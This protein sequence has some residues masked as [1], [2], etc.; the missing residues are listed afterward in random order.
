MKRLQS[1]F[2]SQPWLALLLVTLM[3]LGVISI[4]N[5][6]GVNAGIGGGFFA[7]RPQNGTTVASSALNATPGV[8]TILSV[9]EGGILTS[10]L[11]E[12]DSADVTGVPD[13]DLIVTVDGTP[14]TIAVYNGATTWPEWVQQIARTIATSVVSSV[15]ATYLPAP[16]DTTLFQMDDAGQNLFRSALNVNG[17]G[18]LNS[19]SIEVTEAIVANAGVGA[20]SE[21]YLRII[22]DGV[23][24]DILL[25]SSASN[26]WEADN[27]T[28]VNAPGNGANVGD[29]IGLDLTSPFTFTTN[30]QVGLFQVNPMT[31]GGVDMFIRYSTL[32]GSGGGGGSSTITGASTT[33]TFRWDINAQYL[34]SLVVAVDRNVAGTSAAT[35]NVSVLRNVRVPN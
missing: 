5:P 25:Y 16:L 7:Y 12:V 3:V 27:F 20:E 1:A 15:G 14:S 28:S 34:N 30:L 17:S 33:N 2:A 19:V 6:T 4:V 8:D 35:L 29:I 11:V 21:F 26:T 22:A 32:V 24:S 31:D 18:Q 13:V 9:T 23:T 10:I